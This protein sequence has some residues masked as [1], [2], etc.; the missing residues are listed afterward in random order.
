V[1][2][3]LAIRAA[4]FSLRAPLER[5]VAVSVDNVIYLAG[6]LGS[7]GTS[8]NGVFSLNPST[9][10]LTLIGTVPQAFHDAAGA[11]LDGRLYV[12]GGGTGES[13]DLVQSFDLQGR[14]GSVVGHIPRPLSDVSAATVGGVVYL[15]GGWDGKAWN[16]TVWRTT[17]GRRFAVA[18]HLPEGLRYAAVTVVGTDVVVAGGVDSRNA[19]V[20]AVT[21][22]DPRTGRATTIGRLPIAVGHA[23]A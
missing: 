2:E 4:P 3:R 13:S 19:P 22:F 7:A 1:V 10:A 21:T 9:G 8:A 11:V 6:G 15:L 23:A 17:D 18:G 5:E 14:R 20:D 16:A 12:F